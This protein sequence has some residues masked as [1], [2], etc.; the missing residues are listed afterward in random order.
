MATE[1]NTG[2]SR[3]FSQLQAAVAAQNATQQVTGTVV[4]SYLWYQNQTL[5]FEASTGHMSEYAAVC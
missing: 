2:H 3:T 1:G 4:V 5:L